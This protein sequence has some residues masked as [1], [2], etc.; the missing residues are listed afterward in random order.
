MRL[1]TLKFQNLN[2]LKGEWFIDFRDPAYAD[3]G[4]LPLLA[5][6]VRAKVP[7]WMRFAWHSMAQP[8]DLVI[9]PKPKTT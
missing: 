3:E 4:I 6:L 1:L 7:S 5:Q 9:S 8:R 2:S